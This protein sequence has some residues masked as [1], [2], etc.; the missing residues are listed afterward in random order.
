LTQTGKAALRVSEAT[1]LRAKTIHRFL[2]EC[3]TD[4]NTGAPMFVLKHPREF[5]F[6]RDG[7]WVLIDEA[8][9][10]SKKVLED[11]ERIARAAVFPIVVMGDLFQLPPVYKNVNEEGF[12][13]LEVPTEFSVNL[14]EVHRQAMDSPI[15]R[16]SMALRSN[17]PEF[18]AMRLLRPIGESM[19]VEDA[20]ASRDRGGAVLCHTNARRHGLNCSL[21]ARNG[22]DAGTLHPGEPLLVTQNNYRIDRYN[23]EVVEFRNWA[24]PPEQPYVV[25][26]R[27]SNGALEMY[28]GVG[29]VGV[30]L[31]EELATV[32]VEEVSGKSDEAKIGPWCIRRAARHACGDLT[33]KKDGLPHLHANY[34]YALT[35]HKAQGSEW[36]E[37]IVVLEDSLDRVHGL[38]RRRWLYTAITRARRGVA[39]VRVN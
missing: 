14:T 24:Q 31:V 8:S 22:F 27:Y 10:V 35:V 26:D 7:G 5:E 4:P 17:E 15:I 1:G 11:L 3:E 21:R 30:G 2:Y 32:S 29:S 12:S 38:E 36:P 25:R 9:M 39:Y 33:E 34:G 20:M 23:G 16:A 28:F 6:L 37:I 13:L 19:F 18:V